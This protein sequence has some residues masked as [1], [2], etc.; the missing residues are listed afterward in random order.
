MHDN[1]AD[2]LTGRVPSCV[3]S[4]DAHRNRLAQVVA[5]E[6]RIDELRLELAIQRSLAAAMLAHSKKPAFE[7]V[8][9]ARHG[10]LSRASIHTE[11]ADKAQGELDAALAS[12]SAME[13]SHG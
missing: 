10:F 5:S 9:E 2:L 13:A 7:L 1:D 12:R 11:W 6:E 4:L 3:V 8:R